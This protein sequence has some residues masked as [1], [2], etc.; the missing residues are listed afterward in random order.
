MSKLT[1]NL[2]SGTFIASQILILILGLLFLA[3]LHFILNIQFQ[4]TANLY[5]AGGGPI[6]SAPASLAL[7]LFA[8]SDNQ[9]TFEPQILVSGKTT[10]NLT[11]LITSN[12]Q[13]MVI[14]A[15]AQGSFSTVFN[16]KEDENHISV[17][18]FDTNG[19]ERMLQRTIFYS[20]EKI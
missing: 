12:D 15:N 3:F 11:V 8:P 19:D 18:V 13:N 2:S 9:L 17:V 5:S 1:I 6:T 14:K 20:K 10:P 7:E 16:L 4:P